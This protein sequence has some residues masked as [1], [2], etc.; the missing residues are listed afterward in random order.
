MSN[1]PEFLAQYG[2]VNH[3]SKALNSDDESLYYYAARNVSLPEEHM[4]KIAD[5]DS[6]EG[7]LGLSSNPSTPTHIIRKLTQ[8]SDNEVRTNALLHK[9]VDPNDIDRELEDKQIKPS[10]ISSLV[11][12]SPHLTKD[13]LH[14]IA[15]PPQG[16]DYPLYV[17]DHAFD[18]I[19][20]KEYSD[21]K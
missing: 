16:R 3:V 2:S 9:N 19:Q 8:H 17:R 15:Y 20:N 13:Q 11:H 21:G 12:K 1:K 5:S 10:V 6:W 14:K 7:H 4:K 18:R